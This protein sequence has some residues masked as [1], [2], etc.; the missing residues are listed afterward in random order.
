MDQQGNLNNIAFGRE[1]RKPRMRLPG[2]GG[3]PDVTPNYDHT[4]LYVPRH[5][6]LTF[7]RK[8][9]FISG[10]GHVPHRRHGGGPRY[11]I[12]DLGEFDW[13]EC[14]M[15]LTSIHPGVRV[16]QVKRKT[17]FDLDVADELGETSPP[18]EE[19]LRL[20]REEI[21]P[22]AT[23]KLET[24]AGAA[25]KELLREILRREVAP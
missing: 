6:R 13:A 12:T 21:D 10:M 9:D 11:L 20:L 3:I 16:E 2:S 19:D 7:A 14:R 17:A 1:Y 25:R 18:D 4:Y 23:R 5:S 22:L 15:R 8:I 24:L